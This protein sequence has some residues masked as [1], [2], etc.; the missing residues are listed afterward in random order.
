MGC[1]HPALVP[2]AASPAPSTMS[3]GCG[4]GGGIVLG[5][6]DAAAI[7]GAARSTLLAKM[8]EVGSS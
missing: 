6:A 5:G 7:I 8:H 3:Y 1:P 2:A 4:G